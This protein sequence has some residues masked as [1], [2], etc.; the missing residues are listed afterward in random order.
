MP[1]PPA[2]ERAA[3]ATHEKVV[4]RT[5]ALPPQARPPVHEREIRSAPL[6]LPRRASWRVAATCSVVGDVGGYVDQDGRRKPSSAT[7]AVATNAR[8]SGS[9]PREPPPRPAPKKR[10]E[11][12]ARPAREVER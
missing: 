1:P 10:E 5:A 8:T 7:S 4:A 3:A 11:R 12:R 2:R 6:T 9:V